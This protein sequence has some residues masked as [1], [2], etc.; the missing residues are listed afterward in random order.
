[1]QVAVQR[2][3]T[4]ILLIVLSLL[5]FLM[6][7][8]SRT[9]YLGETRTLMER[10]VMT[11]VS[12]V[13]KLVNWVGEGASDMYYGYLD[14][15]REVGENRELRERVAAL[16]RENMA[17]R[18][19]W[20]ELARMRS[21]LGYAHQSDARM[22][23]ARVIMFDN[24]SLFKSIILDQGSEDG[25]A[26]ND[27]VITPAGLVG[28]I[29]L[30]TRDLAKV[31]LVIDG[32]SSVGARIERTRRQGVVRGDGSGELQMLYVPA[33]ADV[34]VGDEIVTSGT[35]GIY[36][37]GISI[38]RVEAAAEGSDLFKSIE[39]SPAVDFLTLD[40]VLIL[41]TQKIPVQVE[42]WQP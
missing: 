23:M 33:L 42:R 14:M 41:H 26:I 15:R 11:V 22:S 30:V 13:P 4:L 21:M 35:D 20:G 5:F 27:V 7:R 24:S 37:K 18:Q 28:R 16:T 9:R 8:D 40:E 29:V 6:S 31:Q 17:L 39:L 38:G 2:R 25:L 3:P 19:S 34:A 10:M 32:G 36:P 1:M 12:P